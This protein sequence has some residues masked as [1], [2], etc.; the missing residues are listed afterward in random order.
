MMNKVKFKSID[1]ILGSKESRFFGIGYRRVSQN[2]RSINFSTKL[3]YTEVVAVGRVQYPVNW[4]IKSDEIE[5]KPHLSSID[6]LLLAMQFCDCFLS[7]RFNL[8]DTQK[9]KMWLRK[10]MMRAGTNPME[11]IDDFNIS[12]NHIQT[13]PTQSLFC[14]HVTTTNVIVG[15]IKIQCEIE[16][17]VGVDHELFFENNQFI[18]FNFEN[19]QPN[20]HIYENGYKN[21]DHKIENVEIDVE[22]QQATAQIISQYSGFTIEDGMSAAYHPTLTTI[23]CMV[24]IAQLGQALLYTI[25]H[26]PRS[27]TNT[28]WMREIHMQCDNPQQSLSSC[29]ATNSITKTR[30]TPMKGK[31]WRVAEMLGQFHGFSVKYSVAHELPD[32]VLIVV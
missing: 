4:S 11:E 19:R 12:L 23:D 8:S 5:I 24:V 21:V 13:T 22:K 7:I 18:N 6:A 3:N 25:D 28:L 17:D 1:E 30:L 16:H 20:H 29:I 26:I 10:F 32:Q 15:N 14:S 27:E 31:T 9:R 2:I